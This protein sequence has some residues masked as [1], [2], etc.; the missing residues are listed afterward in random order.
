MPKVGGWTAEPGRPQGAHRSQGAPSSPPLAQPPSSA[1]ARLP[2]PPGTAC[3]PPAPPPPAPLPATRLG[4]HPHLVL[5]PRLEALRHKVAGEAQAHHLP[6]NVLVHVRPRRHRVGLHD[7]QVARQVHREPG[8]L[9]AG[10]GVVWV[11]GWV[12]R[13][14]RVRGVGGEVAEGEFWRVRQLG[15]SGVCGSAMAGGAQAAVL[16]LGSGRQAGGGGGAAYLI[17]GMVMRFSGSTRSMRGMRSRAPGLRWL[18]SV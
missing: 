1:P 10:G 2:A 16:L 8:V 17:S 3:H 15:R 7:R 5:L 6:H 14:L 12:M 9:P 4:P 13:R 18:G 11:G